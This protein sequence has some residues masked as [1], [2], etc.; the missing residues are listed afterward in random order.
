MGGRGD[1]LGIDYLAASGKDVVQHER[2][3]RGVVRTTAVQVGWGGG[4]GVREG[5]REGGG[6]GAKGCEAGGE[7]DSTSS[8][9]PYL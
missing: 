3:E 8:T 6:G 4:G 5:G 2:R 9:S 1:R 7:M